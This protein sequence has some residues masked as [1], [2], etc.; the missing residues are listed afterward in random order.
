MSTLRRLPGLIFIS[1]VNA[2]A[3]AVLFGMIPFQTVPDRAV[4]YLVFGLL[5]GWLAFGLFFGSNIARIVMIGAA[6]FHVAGFLINSVVTLTLTQETG[7][8]YGIATRLVLNLAVVVFMVWSASYLL[9][10]LTRGSFTSEGEP[11]RE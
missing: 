7:F 2:I 5:H 6:L 4:A 9:A 1:A 8:T 10:G 3:A 11:E